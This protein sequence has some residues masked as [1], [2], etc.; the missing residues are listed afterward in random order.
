M[1]AAEGPMV[2]LNIINWELKI[3][4]I[5]KEQMMKA[6]RVAHRRGLLLFNALSTECSTSGDQ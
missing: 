2:E 1:A 3:N 5:I 4:W 6:M